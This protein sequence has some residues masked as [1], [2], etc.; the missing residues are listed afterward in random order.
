MEASQKCEVFLSSKQNQ[1]SMKI[2]IYSLLI[3]MTA[4]FCNVVLGQDGANDPTFNPGDTGFGTGP[5]NGIE[6]LAL[7][8]DGKLL[9]GGHFDHYYSVEKHG[10]VRLNSDRTIDSSFNAGAL[11]SGDVL[12]I[13]V[14]PDGKIIL[15]G[16]C[17]NTIGGSCAKLIRL[18]DDGS[19]DPAFSEPDVMQSGFIRGSVV[20]PDGKIIIYGSFFDET[21]NFEKS[22]ARLNV[23]GSLDTSF[24]VGTGANAEVATVVVQSDG[25]LIV[26]GSFTDFN[27]IPKNRL[28]R[29]FADGSVD[30]GFV[31]D[32]LG[33][34]LRSIALL[35]DGKIYLSGS[36]SPWLTGQPNV[37]RLQS[38]GALDTS[39]SMSQA[40]SEGIYNKIIVQPDNKV[41]L[42]GQWLLRLNADG[43]ED[44]Q[45]QIGQMAMSPSVGANAAVLQPDGKLA[46]AGSFLS[47]NGF[48]DNYI[49][50]INANGV[51][52]NTFDAGYG[53][54]A[55]NTIHHIIKVQDKMIIAGDFNHYNG[56]VANRIARI[57]SDGAI[58]TSF[59][60]GSGP[61]RKI[62]FVK[63][64]P[65]GKIIICGFIDSYNGIS[66]NQLARLNADGSLDTSFVSAAIGYDYNHPFSIYSMDVQDDGKILLAGEIE[67][68]NNIPVGN[69][70]RINTDG[71]LDT[72]FN[73]SFVP[74]EA[75]VYKVLGIPGEQRIIVA[76]STASSSPQDVIF[77]VD[78]SGN[79][80]STFNVITS[81]WVRD[82]EDIV[83]RP[84]GKLWI[85]GRYINAEQNFNF[86]FMRFNQNGTHDIIVL[87]NTAMLDPLLIKILPQDDGKVIIT[88]GFGIGYP[89]LS[90]RRIIRL[91][92]D[93][94]QD[95]TFDPGESTLREIFDV[96]P[97][98]DKL[99]IAGTFTSFDGIGRNRIARIYSTGSLK[100]DKPEVR[101]DKI[102]AYKNGNVLD[103]SS[104]TGEIQ[105]VK[106][107]DL[108]GKL[109]SLQNDVNFSST[110]IEGITTNSIYILR[111]RLSDNSIVAKRIFF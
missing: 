95:S 15:S 14:Q 27:G 33:N 88:G 80:D 82:V 6:C 81:D 11:I 37:I 108:S 17:I 64:A 52:D 29:L 3:V 91:N 31:H 100:T 105:D 77:K 39:F 87:D 98:V 73:A 5:D 9:V 18:N 79:P 90:S 24:N 72:T 106:V 10:L 53:T 85:Y 65:N 102:I 78:Y 51:R 22:I 110:Q 32:Y 34:Y 66:I 45:F 55:D 7:Q 70:I 16:E 68:Y 40:Y 97:Q 107:Y 61:N 101:S 50:R 93:G 71:T 89:G 76:A 41:V 8:A 2:K 25:K 13:T 46:V 44:T 48:S 94:S 109:I 92:E 67:S 43:Y 1:Q 35:P 104:L 38:D 83:L 54:G 21:F 19:V 74:N 99:V 20:Q 62:E 49:V 4:F 60:S 75:V 84:D 26:G 58:D 57:T 69:I 30:A 23:D 63:S 36:G 111:V 28:V 42:A 59:S 56:T 96:V 103:I 47:Y 86:R 12:G